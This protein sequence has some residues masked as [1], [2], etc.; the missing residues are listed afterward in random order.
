MFHQLREALGDDELLKIVQSFINFDGSERAPVPLHDAIIESI[1]HDPSM[2]DLILSTTALLQEKPQIAM[3]LMEK[4]YEQASSVKVRQQLKG[5]ALRFRLA[6]KFKKK[7]LVNL[8]Q[9]TA[10]QARAFQR[11][12]QMAELYFS[13]ASHCGVKLRVNP[14]L[15]GPS[16]VG[17]THIVNALAESL[18]LPLLR[19]TVSDWLVTG[20]KSEPTTLQTLQNF[21]TE[22]RSGVVFIDETDKIQAHDNAWSQNVLTELFSVIDRQVNF[23]GGKGT[24][25]TPDHTARLKKKIFLIGAGTWHRLWS[26]SSAPSLGFGGSDARGFDEEAFRKKV[27]HAGLIPDELINRFNDDWL[28]L[29]PYK[30]TDYEAIVRNLGIDPTTIDPVEG[31]ASGLNFRYVERALTNAALKR[32]AT[33]AVAQG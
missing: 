6:C 10:S 22:N 13:G 28:M 29:E 21:L 23:Q 2:I 20:C 33:P 16:G 15:V 25:W 9:F 3:A 1:I 11:L 24:P 26:Q 8:K 27:R 17:K 5:I 4:A 30:V 19:L 18:D 32:I 14:L 31:A 12:R 7:P